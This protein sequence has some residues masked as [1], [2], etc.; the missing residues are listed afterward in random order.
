MWCQLGLEDTLQ[1]LSKQNLCGFTY[2]VRSST[3]SVCSIDPPPSFHLPNPISLWIV[4]S[5]TKEDKIKTLLFRVKW[6]D[7][8]FWYRQD[9]DRR[10]LKC[11]IQ[12]MSEGASYS[13]LCPS[14]HIFHSF[15]I[16]YV[17]LSFIRFFRTFKIHTVGTLYFYIIN[18]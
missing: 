4:T 7:G 2:F 10:N 1:T 16:T 9:I 17:E 8:I 6:V 3:L 12:K 13:V 5:V 18:Y 15:K 11:C 14:F